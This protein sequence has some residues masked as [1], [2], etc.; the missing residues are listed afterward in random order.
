MTDIT[1]GWH[2]RRKGIGGHAPRSAL[3]PA[4]QLPAEVYYPPDEMDEFCI[5][6]TPELGPDG[7]QHDRGCPLRTAARHTA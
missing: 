2:D 1:T 6:C 7:W 3:H 5:G 4:D